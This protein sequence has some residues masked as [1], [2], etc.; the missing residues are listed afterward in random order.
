MQLFEDRPLPPGL[1]LVKWI[2]R[3][4]LGHDSD[5]PKVTVALQK[6]PFET[7]AALSRLS[8]QEIAEILG[9]KPRVA[10]ADELPAP[11]F[12][13]RSMQAGYLPILDIG[14]VVSPD[15]P[16]GR[17][18]R[19]AR[20]VTLD[21]RTY[22]DDLFVR[23][24]LRP[25][26][27]W[28]VSVPFRVLNR[29]EYQLAGIQG[30]HDSRCLMFRHGRTEYIVPKTT[31]FRAFYGFSSK[32]INAFCSGPW[33][34]TA[35]ELISFKQYKSGI[36]TGIDPAS[37]AWH[38]VLESGVPSQHAHRLALLWFDLY[39]RKQAESLYTDSLIQNR[40][41]RGQNLS[42]FASANIP[43]TLDA[44]PFTMAV[45][46]FSLRPFRP[47]RSDETMERFLVT[48]ITGSSWPPADQE[49]RWELHNSNAKSGDQPAGT[50]DR[51][52]RPGKPPVEG[53]QEA[54]GTSTSDP[55]A[56]DAVNIFFASTF[57]YLTEPKLVRQRKDSHE[58]FP[59]APPPQ[60]D[61]AS[62]LVS[63]GEPTYS[64]AAAA[65][66]DALDRARAR[67]Q[68]FEFLVRALDQLVALGKV[69]SFEPVGS[70]DPTFGSTRNGMPCWNLLKNFD[71]RS[72][73]VPK[74]GWEVVR[75]GESEQASDNGAFHSRH[76]R[77]VLILRIQLGDKS[78]LLLE[79]EPR[80]TDTSAYCMMVFEQDQAVQPWLVAPV[81]DFIR[82]TEG[83]LRGN[84]LKSAFASLTSNPVTLLKH[85]Y[86]RERDEETGQERVTGLRTDILE[87]DLLVV[88]GQIRKTA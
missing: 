83:R 3:F 67:S 40:G 78:A 64:E 79:I 1:W 85:W 16:V 4:Q 15:G 17:L 6:L 69:D 18:P 26:P 20:T 5:A 8:K 58:A 75:D 28:S 51:P 9:T 52:Y 31:I 14:D 39:A 86:E 54:T 46:G 11:T 42:W 48:A 23:S 30:V 29:F 27:D 10:G 60:V 88:V 45:Q 74:T 82:E 59:P 34:E 7:A 87:K 81:L 61:G 33:P 76:A 56:N 44:E 72:G 62:M 53:D 41:R 55:S 32:A 24:T 73:R 50:S 38:I 71:R 43:H 25:P 19:I 68:Q 57:E 49:I 13:G 84:D 70:T 37:G 65:P 22:K 77:C 35:K 2:D 80:P 66:A 47:S 12:A 21:R 36:F 63:T